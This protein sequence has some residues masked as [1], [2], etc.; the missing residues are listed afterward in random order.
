MT[1][2]AASKKSAAQAAF[3]RKAA[4]LKAA[5]GRK[6]A[7]SAK[8]VAANQAHIIEAGLAA[9]S[10]Q[11]HSDREHAHGARAPP[12]KDSADEAGKKVDLASL[13][14]R[15]THRCGLLDK[16][17]VL[18]VVGVTYPTLWAWMRDGTFPRSRVVG[19]KS[20]WLAAD[21]ADWLVQLPPRK[22][23]GDQPSEQKQEEFA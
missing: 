2:K 21:I 13:H 5:R 22:L 10:A 11:H 17:E 9:D 6:F 8:L 16:R 19:L 1:S 20:K 18:A 7:P 23:K 14:Q 15:L 12:N 4:V 3:A